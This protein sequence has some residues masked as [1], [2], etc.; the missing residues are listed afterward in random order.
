MSESTHATLLRR[1]T[2]SHDVGVAENP[3][4]SSRAVRLA[5]TKAANDT[6]GLVLTVSSVAEDVSTLDPMLDGLPDGLMLVGLYRQ[7][8]LVGM[9]AL[10]MQLR[11]AVLEMETMGALSPQPVDDRAP[12]RTDKMMCGPLIAG[13]L[14]AFPQAV[15]GTDFDGWGDHI[16]HED[17]IA[18]TRTAGLLL[19]DCPYRVVQM[20]VQLGSADRQGLLLMVL[21]LVEEL[22]DAPLPTEIAT[23]WD[24]DFP[25][26][27]QDAP[28]AMTALLHR[29]S[30]T[31]ATARALQVGT[32]LPLPGC[33][34]SSVRLV[35]PDGHEVAQA[36]L[37]Q[38]GGMRAVRLQAA[39]LPD[40]HD[41][42][43]PMG[44]E[45][46]PL[47]VEGG[48]DLPQDLGEPAAFDTALAFEDD[49]DPVV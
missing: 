20:N 26:A 39:P 40:L 9:I 4:T 32:V 30:L 1:M 41:L 27:V 2:R 37:G 18:D 16:V 6:V 33:S 5:L 43:A 19:D 24:V 13:F 36:R 3:L 42:T 46:E 23:D 47:A 28:A 31:L 15:R 22:Q 14:D 44:A 35:A 21:P 7:D 11:A 48:F 12:T 29:F 49:A 45:P 38:S 17:Q 8:R 10:D 34:V 25:K